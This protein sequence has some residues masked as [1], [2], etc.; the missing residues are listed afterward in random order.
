[1]EIIRDINNIYNLKIENTV[2][3]LGKFDGIHL[4][5]NMIMEKLRQ[6]KTNGYISLV[7]TFSGNPLSRKKEREE[8]KIFTEEEQML[9]YEKLGIDIIIVCPVNSH[10]LDM[11]PEEFIKNIL[12]EKIGVKKVICG[13]NFRFGKNRSGDAAKLK[14]LG[15]IYGYETEIIKMISVDGS[16][17]S[18]TIIREL[19]REGN[20][21]KAEKLL[22][23]K[24]TIVGKIVHGNRIGRTLNT[25]TANIIP[26]ENKLLPPNGVYVSKCKIDGKYYKGVTNIGYKPTVDMEKKQLGVE[27]YFLD[28][29]GDLYGKVLEI[30]LIKHTRPEK[31]FNNLKELERQLLADK[32]ECRKCRVDI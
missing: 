29:D 15:A 28:Y 32:D 3:A 20:I 5:H 2:A 8:K 25:P 7:F 19:I 4:G 10:I 27:T 23:H 22:G 12:V 17:V 21:E 6:G 30:E 18:S 26:P 14:E 31:K 24:Y 13:E 9:V 1:M 11:S 16:I